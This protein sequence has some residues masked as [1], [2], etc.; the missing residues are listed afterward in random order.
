MVSDEARLERAERAYN[1]FRFNDLIA[2][3]STRLEPEALIA[4]REARLEARALLGAALFQQSQLLAAPTE[5]EALR[6]RAY[7]QFLALLREEP[8]YR[9]DPYL[10]PSSVLDFM[11]TVREEHS[12][13]LFDAS[14]YNAKTPGQSGAEAPG[15]PII[16][17]EKSLRRRRRLL[18]LSPF[19]LGQ[20]QN[21]QNTKGTALA[22]FQGIGL[23]ANVFGY[24]R[25]ARA[26]G[27]LPGG[28]FPRDPTT[29]GP[30]PEFGAAQAFR[31]VQY[32]GLIVFATFYA[33]SVVDGFYFYEPDELLEIKTLDGP[34]PELQPQRALPPPTGGFEFNLSLSF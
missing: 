25:N 14:P 31:R 26:V 23:L 19:A 5:G 6:Q 34:P 10:F 17:V 29:N 18:I 21:N 32:G 20:F 2:L 16:Y 27:G 30:T 7:A 33:A 3:L 9:L 8:A 15:A 13:E 28:R 4:Q 12:E 24:V 22:I 11:E 1:D